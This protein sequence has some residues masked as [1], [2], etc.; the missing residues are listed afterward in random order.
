MMSTVTA[1]SKSFGRSIFFFGQSYLIACQPPLP[2]AAEVTTV[3]M[4]DAVCK[5]ILKLYFLNVIQ[6]MV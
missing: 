4:H 2:K 1:K 6:D 3:D 5:M